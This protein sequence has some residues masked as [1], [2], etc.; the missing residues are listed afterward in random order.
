[1]EELLY[2]KLI[3]YINSVP[4]CLSDP[5]SI[6]IDSKPRNFLKIWMLDIKFH[7]LHLENINDTEV[8]DKQH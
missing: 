1:M 2:Q 8:T 5:Q 6:F 7:V 4:P 3:K